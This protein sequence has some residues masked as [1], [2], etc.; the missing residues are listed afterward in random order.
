MASASLSSAGEKPRARA[1][2]I[3]AA[4][5]EKQAG[6]QDASDKKALEGIDSTLPARSLLLFRWQAAG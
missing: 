5:E 2:A 6:L 3:T 1:A 4:L